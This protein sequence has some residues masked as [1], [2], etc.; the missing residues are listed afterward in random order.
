VPAESVTKSLI[1]LII[2]APALLSRE[3]ECLLHG[4]QCEGEYRR[5]RRERRDASDAIIGASSLL[6]KM[7]DGSFGTLAERP[8]AMSSWKRLLHVA[9]APQGVDRRKS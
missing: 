8:A 3:M 9:V 4:R 1:N 6:R 2:L 7:C 5:R